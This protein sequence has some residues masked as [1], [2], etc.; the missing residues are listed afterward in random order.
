MTNPSQSE[1]ALADIKQY[2]ANV[3]EYF[4]G[5]LCF[6]CSGLSQNYF[7]FANGS[8]VIRLDPL[9]CHRVFYWFQFSINMIW[10][11]NRFIFPM[12]EFMKCI[13]DKMEDPNYAIF[14]ADDPLL[15]EKKMEVS[16]CLDDYSVT[17]PSCY[18]KCAV[19]YNNFSIK[20]N[21]LR[22]F[23]QAL[24]SS[25]RLNPQLFR[26]SCSTRTSKS[27]TAKRRTSPPTS[28]PWNTPPTLSSKSRASSPINTTSRS[29]LTTWF[30]PTS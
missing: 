25:P 20:M 13:K 4:S 7:Y 10:Y 30:L 14:L 16:V 12:M 19:N 1:K 9:T 26:R 15:D 22:G 24:K 17:D 2:F 18:K 8:F 11:F 21:F 27:T 28:T 29:P 23:K 3:K 6:L 5:T